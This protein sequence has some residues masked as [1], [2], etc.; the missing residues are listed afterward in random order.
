[1]PR[2]VSMTTVTLVKIMR[3]MLKTA[4]VVA[5]VASPMGASAAAAS[6]PEIRHFDGT[7]EFPPVVSDLPCLEGQQFLVSGGQSFHGTFVA[8]NGFLHVTNIEKFFATAVPVDG[9]GPTYVEAPNVNKT[10]FTTRAVSARDEIV[11]TNVNNDRFLGYVDGQR[12]TS[13]TIRIHQVEHFV[14]LDTD[15]D[16]EPDAFKVSVTINDF[17]CPA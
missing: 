2:E 3:P 16:G 14:A 12:V 6:P 15:G 10:T 5:A 11:S 4:P 9:Q 1:M 13:A 17:S 7:M 8:D